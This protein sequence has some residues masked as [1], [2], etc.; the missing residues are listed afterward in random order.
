MIIICKN[1]VLYIKIMKNINKYINKYIK[2]K[3]N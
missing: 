2:Y 1:Y 3:Y